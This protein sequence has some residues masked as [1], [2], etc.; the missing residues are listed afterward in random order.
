MRGWALPRSAGFAGAG[1]LV[2]ALHGSDSA[3]IDLAGRAVH[4]CRHAR[5]LRAGLA[6]RAVGWRRGAGRRARRSCRRSSSRSAS[7]TAHRSGPAARRAAPTAPACSSPRWLRSRLARRRCRCC[8]PP[9][10]PCC[11]S[12][13]RIAARRRPSPSTSP[14][15]RHRRRLCRC[16]RFAAILPSIGRR[17]VA[18]LPGRRRSGRP[19][20]SSPLARRAAAWAGWGAHRRRWS[21]SP[22]LLARLR[23]SRPR[24]AMRR[25]SRS[26][27]IVALVA[28]ARW[29]ARRERRRCRAGVPSPSRSGRR[30]RIAVVLML[31]MAFGPRWTTMLSAPPPSLPALA[32]RWRPYPVLGWLCGRAVGRR[33]RPRRHR[34]DHRRRGILWRRRRSS[35]RCC[36]ATACR[37]SPS[38]L[39]P[40]NWRAPPAAARGWS[41]R[42]PRRCSR[43]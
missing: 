21:S 38:P 34:P 42:R 10:S 29:I 24:P 13:L 40:G 14:A 9:A 17:L 33:A 8:T 2:P 12:H 43:C 11:W 25:S 36:P 37:R 16:S 30:R 4:Q 27:L 35:T 3:G 19:R 39:P 7:A 32:T 28:A 22:A 20:V 5:L 15:R 31:H 23:Q 6:A 1:A 41:W 18:L 26:S